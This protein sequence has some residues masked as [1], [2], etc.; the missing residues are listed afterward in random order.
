MKSILKNQEFISTRPEGQNNELRNLIEAEGGKLL[1]MPTIEIKA[2]N[3]SIDEED[4]LDHISQYS[5]IVFT[6]P[7]G[8]R[9]FFKKLYEIT[10]SYELPSSIKTAVV[11][12][13]TSRV[14]ADFGH[15]ATFVN[16]GNTA[17][18]LAEELEKAINSDDLIL[19]PE[20]DIAQNVISQRLSKIADCVNL[21]VYVND[22]PKTINKEFLNKIIN[23]QYEAII[24]TSP[25]TFNNLMIALK[26]KIQ[27][28]KLRLICIGNTTANEVINSGLKPIATASMSNIAGIFDAILEYSKN[29]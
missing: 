4:M 5:W 22:I 29:K 27:A 21:I 28:N 11:G 1:E 18:D 14:L 15:E 26:N 17:E 10:G 24:L 16:P 20:G 23:D 3:L 9:Y 8:I 7:N 6:S 2:A 12:R 25:S 13:K 19:F